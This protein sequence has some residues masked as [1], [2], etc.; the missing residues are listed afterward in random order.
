MPYNFV[1]GRKVKRFYVGADQ[2]P[3]LSRGELIVVHNKGKY[4]LINAEIAERVRQKDAGWIVVA[5]DD[6]NDDAA[7][8]KRLADEEAA[9][10]GFEIPDDLDW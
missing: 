8:T 3:L 6:S 7:S 4:Y 10:E 5:H 2:V 9:Y 1:H